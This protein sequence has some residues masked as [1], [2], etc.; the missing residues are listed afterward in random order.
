MSIRQ[1]RQRKLRAPNI[2]DMRDPI[3]IWDR[4]I[5]SP[6]FDTQSHTQEYTNDR[7]RFAKVETV[8][9]KEIFQGTELLGVKTHEFTI[10]KEDLVVTSENII[11]F[12]GNYIAIL[13]VNNFEERGTFL[14][15]ECGEK[16]NKLLE[17]T[18]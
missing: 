12:D 2:G 3:I 9:G 15:M 1:A 4:N 10:R 6:K 8:S 11:E 14:L 17:S 16:G 13:R 18:Q 7:T 5:N